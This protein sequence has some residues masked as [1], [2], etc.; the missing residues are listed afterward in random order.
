MTKAIKHLENKYGKLTFGQ[1]VWSHRK[2]EEMS[3]SELA[4]SLGVSK[5]Y[6]S[7]IEN[8]TRCA[9]VEQAARLADVF[10]MSPQIFVIRA[11]QDQVDKAGIHLILTSTGIK[12]S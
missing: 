8:G 3:Q 1:L 6:I 11:L 10:E 9:S 12:R 2:S 5:Q 7:Q 4:D